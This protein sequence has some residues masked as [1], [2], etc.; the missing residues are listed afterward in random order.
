MHPNCPDC[1]DGVGMVENPPEFV[2]CRTC[3][4]SIMAGFACPNCINVYRDKAFKASVNPK[5]KSLVVEL[6]PPVPNENEGVWSMVVRDMLA[7]DQEGRRKYGMPLRAFNGRPQLVDA[8]QEA[9]DFCVYLRAKIEEERVEHCLLEKAYAVCVA[10]SR[11]PQD[12]YALVASLLQQ[13]LKKSPA[14]N[15]E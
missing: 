9:L 5:S 12:G 4:S 8:F 13:I 7:R 14:P 6:P 11:Q 15:A 1:G 10:E 3:K 2:T